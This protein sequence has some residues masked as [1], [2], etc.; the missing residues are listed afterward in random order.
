VVK[1]VGV[2]FGTSFSTEYDCVVGSELSRR[3]STDGSGAL[4]ISASIAGTYSAISGRQERREGGKK[5][6]S[7]IVELDGGV[8]GS[9]RMLDFSI[10]GEKERGGVLAPDVRRC[11]KCSRCRTLSLCLLL[12]IKSVIEVMTNNRPSPKTRLFCAVLSTFI[13]KKVI[14]T[15]SL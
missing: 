14:E 9:E 3:S 7:S 10:P 13:S 1:P 2:Y 5:L 6:M 15:L 12:M 11:L 4:R 8:S